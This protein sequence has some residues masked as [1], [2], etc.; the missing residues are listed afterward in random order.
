MTEIG[1]IYRNYKQK[2]LVSK[3]DHQNWEEWFNQ[4][5]IGMK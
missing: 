5:N 4:Y 2:V 1:K 3:R